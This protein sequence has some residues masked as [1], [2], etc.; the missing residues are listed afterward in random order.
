MRTGAK[1]FGKIWRIGMDFQECL[2]KRASTS[3]ALSLCLSMETAARSSVRKGTPTPDSLELVDYYYT[4]YQI[5]VN[6]NK[7][8]RETY[9]RCLA[10]YACRTVLPD[11]NDMI[12][13]N[14]DY[15]YQ[16]KFLDG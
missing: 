3:T 9:Y 13:A 5:T 14:Y 16:H 8:Y 6:K 10:I 15:F 12:N 11:K 1:S 2:R 4:N 7:V